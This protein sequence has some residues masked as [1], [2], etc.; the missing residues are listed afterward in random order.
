[1]E[2]VP[3]LVLLA[4]VKKVVDFVRYSKAGDYNAIATQLVAWLAGFGLVALA[5]HTSWAKGIVFGEVTL[6]AMGL[7]SQALAGIALGSAASLAHDA[8]TRT[9]PPPT[10]TR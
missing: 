10:L 9:P 1:M 4:T 2:F 7:A 5:A 8:V 6:A 3:V